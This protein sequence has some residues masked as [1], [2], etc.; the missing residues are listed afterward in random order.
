MNHCYSSECRRGSSAGDKT[1]ALHD[2]TTFNAAGCE[3][4]CNGCRGSWLILAT[5]G[6]P[7]T[8]MSLAPHNINFV[9]GGKEMLRLSPEGFFVEGRKVTH[10]AEVYYA[11]KEWLERVRTT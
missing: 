7:N 10:D 1:T 2:P 4:L 11:F 3:C 8:V 5:D 6:P 9:I